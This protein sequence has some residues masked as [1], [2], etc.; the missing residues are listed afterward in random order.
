MSKCRFATASLLLFAASAHAQDAQLRAGVYQN[1]KDPD[2]LHG[3]IAFCDP[4]PGWV[5]LVGQGTFR[6]T[7]NEID[8]KTVLGLGS[9]P[10]EVYISDDGTSLIPFSDSARYWVSA[11]LEWIKA[12]D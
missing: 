8:G 12:C 5:E 4:D 10:L 1:P 3:T 6:F 2:A 9:P 11:P 7:V